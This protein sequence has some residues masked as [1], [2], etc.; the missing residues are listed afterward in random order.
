MARNCIVLLSIVQAVHM[1]ENT[2]PKPAP[3][4]EDEQEETDEEE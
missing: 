4:T 1:V 2:I 3:V